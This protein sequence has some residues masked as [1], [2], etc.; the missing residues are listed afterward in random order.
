MA[1]ADIFASLRLGIKFDTKRFHKD[2]EKFAR[3]EKENDVVPEKGVFSFRVETSESKT[4][5]SVC[6]ALCHCELR[7]DHEFR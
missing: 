1:E 7:Q 4:P 5:I 2:I 3:R 6:L